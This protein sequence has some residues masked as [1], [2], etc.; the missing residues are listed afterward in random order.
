MKPRAKPRAKRV[1]AKL[2]RLIRRYLKANPHKQILDAARLFNVN[3]GR[4]SEAL[5]GDR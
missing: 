5:H 3:P 4:V 1:D 2:A